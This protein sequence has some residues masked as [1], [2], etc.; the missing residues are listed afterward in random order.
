[1][2][3][4]FIEKNR[5]SP[6]PPEKVALRR[7]GRGQI[8]LSGVDCDKFSDDNPRIVR[9]NFFAAIFFAKTAD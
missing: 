6:P 8:D 1:V 7:F 5:T 9:D 2:V 4:I 3:A